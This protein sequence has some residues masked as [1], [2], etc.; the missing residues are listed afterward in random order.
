MSSHHNYALP[1][2]NNSRK[3]CVAIVS[4]LKNT[5]LII[6]IYSNESPVL[7]KVLTARLTRSFYRRKE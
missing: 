7:W 3:F 6:V 5:S 2:A 4:N 1:L